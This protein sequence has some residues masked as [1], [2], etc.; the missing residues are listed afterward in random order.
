[1][2]R[3][4]Q[5]GVVAAAALV[6]T[7]TAPA[8]GAHAGHRPAA[9]PAR[10]TLPAGDGWAAADGGTTGGSAADASRVFTVTTWEEFRDALAVPGTEPRIVKVAGVLNATAAGC[11]AFEA[12]GYD[13]A[14]YLA[15]YDPAVWG[16][17]NEVSGPQEELRAASATAQ[18]KAVKANVPANTTI[19]GVGRH[20]GITGGSLQVQGVDNVVV[21]NLTLESP[22]DCF[23][24]WD[25]TDGAT[26]AWN[27]EY[28]SLVVYGS[29]H[30]WIDHNTFT[31]G[32]HPD[33][34][35]PSYY[36][37]VYQQHDGELD[38]VRGADLVT[39]SW[40]VFT[41]H[42]K[43]LMIGNSDSA[44]ATDRGRLRVTLHHNLFENVVERAPRVRFGQVD[45]YNNHFVVPGPAYVYSLG[46]GQESQ[47]VAEKNAFTL[48]ADV[49]AGKI[50]K[51]WKDAPVTTTGN[52]VNG[53]PV[54]LLAAHNAQYPAEQL[55]GD[56]GWTP[57]LRTRVD[58][59][60]AVPALVGH[61][62]G[63]GR[64]R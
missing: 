6:L 42:D 62:A 38:V 45:A 48:A 19:V 56:A 5:L 25:P 41:D 18:G 12:P 17:E 39:A 21:R 8:A 36:G 59:P 28:D 31:D 60:K 63:A 22:L 52:Y 44:G 10:A 26:G 20:A 49:P 47:L 30:V 53:G 40:N 32:A 54:D 51:K 33:S 4:K 61:H 29:T 16:Y 13:F 34:S 27:S 24:Q 15:D 46:I 3:R 57:V 2:N 55:R 14:R 7:V 58:H 9:D 23:P 43:T 50:L 35:L 64:L 37:E 11:A 1:M